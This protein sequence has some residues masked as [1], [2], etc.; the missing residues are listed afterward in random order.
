M[1]DDTCESRRIRPEPARHTGC[2]ATWKNWGIVGLVVLVLAALAGWLATQGLSPEVLSDPHR[3]RSLI[4]GWGAWG[5]L[6]LVG[7]QILQILLAP[8]PGQVLGLVGGYLYGP[9]LGSVFNMTGTLVGSGLAM[10][11]ARRFGR[12]LVERLVSN[13]WLDRLDGFA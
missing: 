4:L 7:L 3:L 9:W 6:A 10:W 5:G 13:R 8:M 2:T 1:T 12:P 11:L